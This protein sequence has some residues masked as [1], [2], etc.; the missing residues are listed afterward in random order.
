MR[1]ATARF[2][3]STIQRKFVYFFV[4]CFPKV[5]RSILQ[6]SFCEASLTS[7]TNAVTLRTALRDRSSRVENEP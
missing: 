2:V 7:Y 4:F 3:I 1:L 6:G 5:P